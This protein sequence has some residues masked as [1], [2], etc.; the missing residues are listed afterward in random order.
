VRWPGDTREIYRHYRGRVALL[1]AMME[2]NVFVTS[3][4]TSGLPGW[5]YP[6]TGALDLSPYFLGLAL[7]VAL[8][9]FINIISRIRRGSLI[10]SLP[11]LWGIG[12]VYVLVAGSLI[13]VVI[14]AASAGTMLADTYYVVAHFSYVARTAAVFAVLAGWYL[15]FPRMTGFE[16][17]ALLGKLH[18]WLAFLGVNLASFPA[19]YFGVAG[20]PQRYADYSQTFARA[21]LV[22]TVGAMIVACSFVVFLFATG[23]AIWRKRRAAA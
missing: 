17:S 23:E 5:A 22:S 11:M 7:L 10:F 13:G 4:H 14:R 19:Y 12:V 9:I 8:P 15:F 6:F 16:Y 1:T 21:N 20:R 18:F 3:S 2:N